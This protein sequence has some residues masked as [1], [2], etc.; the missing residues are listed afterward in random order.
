MSLIHNHKQQV[1]EVQIQEVL[2][3]GCFPLEAMLQTILATISYRNI[4]K[5]A[6][7]LAVLLQARVSIIMLWRRT[8]PKKRMILA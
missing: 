1:L 2:V 5:I 6:K 4:E 7:L 3:R 8:V